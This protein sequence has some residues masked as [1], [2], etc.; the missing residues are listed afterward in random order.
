MPKNKKLLIGLS[1]IPQVLLIKWLSAYPS[2]VETFYSKGLY[3]LISKSLRYA[4]GWLPFSF[5]DLFYS[6]SIIYI[7]RWLFFNFK[8]IKTDFKG[9]FIDIL[10]TI[11]VVY[12]AFHLFWGMNYY[13]LPL[14]QHLN[15]QTQYTT[16]QLISTTE[17]LIVQANKIHLKITQDSTQKV[18]SPY[19]NDEVFK[20]VP[21][22][23]HKL[24][25][26]FPNL[27]YTP[28]SIKKSLFSLPLT[29][30]GFSGYLNPLTNE[31]QVD[32]LVPSFKIPMISSHEVAHQLG[33]AAENEAN[34][35]GI[36]AA[37]KHPDNYFKY[38]GTIFALKHCLIETFRRDSLAYETLKSKVNIGILKNYQEAQNFWTDYENPLE[39]IF[40]TTYD[41]FLKANNQSDGME[42]YNYVVALLVNYFDANN[43]KTN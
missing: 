40:K 25:T 9:F 14:H 31:A 30:M 26:E 27:D 15:L 35:I 20:K 12:L 37:S 6:L 24:K 34:F 33:F 23:F 22:G 3:V 7:I 11:S 29:Y 38:S 2:V 17:R 4:L 1:I 10:C 21:K 8:R 32:Y 28:K 43:V 13:R 36:L 42:S 18:V 41:G 19:S 16:E 5:G 39:P